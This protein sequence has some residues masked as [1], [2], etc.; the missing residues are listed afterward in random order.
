MGFLMISASSG[1]EEIKHVVIVASGE[2]NGEQEGGAVVTE[3]Q[4]VFIPN[5]RLLVGHNEQKA[6]PL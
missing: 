6:V 3:D 1:K 4:T 2:D 5:L